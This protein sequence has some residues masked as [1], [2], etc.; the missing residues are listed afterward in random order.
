[1]PIEQN[2]ALACLEVLVAIM[3]ADGKIDPAEKKSLAAA[4]EAFDLP[5]ASRANAEHLLEGKID[6]DAA[7]AKITSDEGREQTYRSAY[8]MAHADGSCGQAEADLLS[9]VEA[10]TKPSDAQKA[11]LSQLFGSRP[12]GKAA[13]LLEAVSGLFKKKS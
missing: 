13:S 11:R 8:F 2:E 3:K 10:A 1:M 6:V 4:L 7:L 5:P 12:K 9:R